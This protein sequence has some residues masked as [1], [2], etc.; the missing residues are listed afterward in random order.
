[1]GI[2]SKDKNHTFYWIHEV[3]ERKTFS[4]KYVL[5]IDFG[6]FENKNDANQFCKNLKNESGIEVTPFAI[7]ID[8]DTLNEFLN[9]G[10]IV[11]EKKE[12]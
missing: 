9:S 1:M 5:R 12:K 6:M 11:N 3:T 10:G 4:K 2:F 7:Q 8:D